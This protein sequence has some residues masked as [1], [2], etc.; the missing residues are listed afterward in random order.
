MI[1]YNPHDGAP[2]I[3]FVYGGVSKDPHYPDGYEMSTGEVSNGLLQY[4]QESGLAILETYAFLTEV[5]AEEAKK[6]LNRPVEPKFKCDFPGCEFSS[7]AKIGLAGH[8]RSHPVKE[9]DSK[10]PNALPASLIPVSG[11]RKVISLAEKKKMIDNG[12]D[13]HIPNGPDADGVDWYG[14]GAKIENPNSQGFAGT[15]QVGKGHFVG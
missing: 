5:S 12:I 6:I 9:L 14:E 11:G 3:G 15:K 10:D 13:P 7:T 4:D 2:I 1:V 8:K